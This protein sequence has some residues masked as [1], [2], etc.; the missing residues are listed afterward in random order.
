MTS[1]SAHHG[2][3]F[4]KVT[5][6]LLWRTPH[7][8]FRDRLEVAGHDRT[9]GVRNPLVA[10]AAQ[11]IGGLGGKTGG[12]GR[13]ELLEREV[14]VLAQRLPAAEVLFERLVA[15]RREA[16]LVLF[17][18]R[19]PQPALLGAH[20]AQRLARSLQLT[21]VCLAGLLDR[22]RPVPG[23]RSLPCLTSARF[24]APRGTGT[25]RSAAAVAG[26]AGRGLCFRAAELLLQPVEPVAHL[27]RAIQLV[28]ELPPVIRPAAVQRI[29]DRLEG[30]GEL[31]LALRGRR[32][33]ASGLT[34]RAGWRGTGS[35]PG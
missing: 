25:R 19:A 26:P 20:A 31:L 35:R 15:G 1:T 14:D 21:G 29:G 28:S 2:S 13:L 5:S 17:R 27:T 3:G 7:G 16:V 32:R 30:A 6:L 11:A 9:I 18:R 10:A 34:L 33:R 8:G 4:A 12:C 22:T 24:A 23:S